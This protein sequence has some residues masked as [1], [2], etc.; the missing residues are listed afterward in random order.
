MSFVARLLAK[1]R[2]SPA[3]QPLSDDDIF[4]QRLSKMQG[5]ARL[6]QQGTPFRNPR[7]HPAT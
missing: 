3:V 7:L 6:A 2:S 4:A 5:R 1:F